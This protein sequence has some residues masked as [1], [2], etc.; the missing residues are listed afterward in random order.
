MYVC[1][2]LCVLVM[3]HSIQFFASVERSMRDTSGA[4]RPSSEE[5]F[6]IM[7]AF[8]Q[9]RKGREAGEPTFSPKINVHQKTG[10]P[11]NACSQSYEDKRDNQNDQYIETSQELQGTLRG[12]QISNKC[13]LTKF[14]SY[15]E[16]Q[17]WVSTY[18]SV[19]P[20][21]MFVCQVYMV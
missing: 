5:T 14:A 11:D 15:K 21:A 6:H 16:I 12:G 10:Y 3:Y 19:V 2:Y 4:C 8:N 7:D 13:M 20:L 1:V 17:V 9:M 18:G